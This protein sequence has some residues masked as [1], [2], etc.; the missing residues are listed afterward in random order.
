MQSFDLV[1]SLEHGL[2]RADEVRALVK[3][4]Y[5]E[6]ENVDELQK[7]FNENTWDLSQ[8]LTLTYLALGHID[9]IKEQINDSIRMAKTEQQDS[10]K[11]CEE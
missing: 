2:T 7:A 8:A 10:E 4:L 3:A 9:T 11:E 1:N 6:L 5:T